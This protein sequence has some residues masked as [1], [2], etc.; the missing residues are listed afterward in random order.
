MFNFKIT[1]SL[2]RVIERYAILKRIMDF[3]WHIKELNSSK[4]GK[5][6]PC[7]GY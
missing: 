1:P 3:A 2:W 6:S 4:L 7:I 5:G